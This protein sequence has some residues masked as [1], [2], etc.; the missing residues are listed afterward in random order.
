MACKNARAQAS[1]AG[2]NCPCKQARPNSLGFNDQK[3]KL[4]NSTVGC[5]GIVPSVGINRQCEQ[6]E[7]E[8]GTTVKRRG[9]ENQ[10]EANSHALASTIWN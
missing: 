10:I 5:V 8:K 2:G 4:S 3:G 6:G 1:H 9:W 7:G